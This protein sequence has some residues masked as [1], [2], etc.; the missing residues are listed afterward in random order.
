MCLG[1]LN[2]QSQSSQMR[3]GEILSDVE[4]TLI[5]E[6]RSDMKE[7]RGKEK[8]RKRK[9]VAGFLQKTEAERAEIL[10]QAKELISELKVANSEEAKA[11]I[12]EELRPLLEQLPTKKHKKKQG[13]RR[14]GPKVQQ[15]Q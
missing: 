15:N 12:L 3:P 9:L 13:T 6:I 11:Q 5:K 7:F 10:E 14:K 4:K 1:A 2:A 8:R